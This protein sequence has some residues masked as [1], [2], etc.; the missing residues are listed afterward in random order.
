MSHQQESIEFIDLASERVGGSIIEV[1]DEFFAPADNMLKQGRGIF[2]ADKYTENGKWMDGWESRRKRDA[3]HDHC[4]IKLGLRGIIK[5]L[6]IDTNHFLGNHPPFASVDACPT[7]ADLQSG[8]WTEILSKSELER[9]SQNIFD[10]KNSESYQFIRLNIYPDG[11]VARFRVYGKVT[12]DLKRYQNGEEL[13]L[14]AVENGGKVLFCND[15]FF[16]SK[17]NLIIPGRG[18]NMG[19]GWE[20]KRRRSPGNDWVVL[21]C[22]AAGFIDRVEIDTHFFKGNFPDQCLIEGI[23]T[24]SASQSELENSKEWEPLFSKVK[25]KSNQI[26]HFYTDE[27]KKK[28]EVTHIRMQI[29]PDGGISRL[30]TWGRLS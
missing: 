24:P 21:Q 23:N 26:H 20:T 25:L 1:T 22:G 4:I 7:Y 3:G 13:D 16:S 2:I 17:D 27:D 12:P 14:V 28:L 19:D 11:G 8:N 6:D 5:K 15:M 29:F 18:I 9:G 30:R 10:V